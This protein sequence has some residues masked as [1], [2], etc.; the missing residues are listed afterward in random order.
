MADA[1]L[2]FDEDKIDKTTG[3]YDLYS[4]F[5][6]GMRTANMVDAPDYS[7]NP[8]V[9][10]S[11]EI[12]M[13]M[14]E[15]KLA[16]YA[17]ILM[18]NSA[19][20]MANSIMTVVSGDGS[21]GTAG[22]GFLSRNGDNMV[23]QLGALYGFQ[24]GYNN[25]IIF[26]TTINAENKN[27]A[28]VY[29]NLVVDEGVTIKGQL[30]L[31]NKGIYISDH[32]A[33]YYVDDKLHVDSPDIV[34]KGAL[35]I[36]GSF[37]LGD[38]IIN[39][40]G[41]FNGEKEFYHQGNC[42]N[43]KTD[44]GMRDAH[45]YGKLIVDGQYEQKGFF[46]ALFGFELG[47]SNKKLL[48]SLKN[49]EDNSVGL[50]L[51]TD[52]SLWTGYGI[53]F[54]ENYIVKVRGGD[55]N[56]VSFS[57]PGMVMNLGDSDGEKITTRIAL[58]T[59]IY[60]HN[61]DYRIISQYGDGNF[62]NSLSAG[63]GNSGP[64]VLQTYYH[65]VDDCGVI[66]Q[67]K[68][69][70]GSKSGPSLF[71]NETFTDLQITIPY[72]HVISNGGNTITQTNNIPIVLSYGETTSL[73]KNQSLTWSASLHLNTDAEFFTFIKPVEA[74]SFS[75]ISEKYKTRLI[76]NALFFDDGT[77]L[78]GIEDGIRHTGNAYFTN[79][80]SS[81]RFASGFAGYG[82]GIIES[83]LNGNVTATFDE[84]TIRK[85]MRVYEFEVQKSSVTNGSL[86]VSSSCSG[87]LVEEIL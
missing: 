74:N 81:M 79:N 56:V 86:W 49:D 43:E 9:T 11:G 69:R 48:Y 8:P 78:E 75:I 61:S 87:D 71:T 80:L 62:K 34:I 70:L 13:E 57:A 29:G 19:Y 58:Q 54:N 24:A 4:R 7:T 77:F 18:K 66:F 53:K 36:D 63:C 42:N 50:Q 51:A 3:L 30:N 83:K 20:M 46:S 45:V 41:L 72:L 85:K 82:W 44:W 84:L 65:S 40:N 64:T 28:H 67:R 10:D 47:E 52:L 5:Y 38:I 22:I 25:K 33:I 76:E 12:D 73:F 17:E 26:D 14:I 23:G 16:E 68:I 15:N 39:K 59:G 37:K 31:S 32:Q 2:N 55:D 6:E 60:N 35:N 27:I 21:G 1:K